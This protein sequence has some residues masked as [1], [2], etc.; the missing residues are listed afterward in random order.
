MIHRDR[1]LLAQVSVKRSS[2]TRQCFDVATMNMLI[3]RAYMSLEGTAEVRVHVC[4][5]GARR[6]RHTGAA[7]CGAWS[8]L[9]CECAVLL[10]SH[11]GAARD[12]TQRVV[13]PARLT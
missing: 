13:P 6:V 12:C 3:E 5:C 10:T 11:S 9:Y 8:V 4:G 1:N 7:S 2:V